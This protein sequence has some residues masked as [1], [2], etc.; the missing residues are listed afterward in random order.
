MI[1]YP[2]TLLGVG[3]AH[4]GL[5]PVNL[6]DVLDTNGNLY[7]WADRAMIA[8]CV[9]GTAGDAV[10]YVPWLLGA[11]PF[12]FNRSMATDS[13]SFKVQNVSGDTLMRDLEGKIRASTIEGALFVYRLWDAAAQSPYLLTMG[14]LGLGTRGDDACSFKTK[15]LSDPAQEDTPLEEYCETCQLNWAGPRCGATGATECLY[16]FQS[17]QVVERIMVAINSFEKN[18][19]ETSANSPLT[20]MNRTRRI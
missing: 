13:G 11:G 18:W 8:P 19:G 14:T 1:P 9:I 6:L 10:N 20:V 17:C 7:Y 15:P 3:G 5:P 16:S 2:P 4:T 12:T